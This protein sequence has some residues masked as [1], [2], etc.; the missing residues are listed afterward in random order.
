MKANVSKS[1]A[2]GIVGTIV[3]SLVILM[4]PYMGMP[5][6]SPPA[7]VAGMLGMP[8]IVGWIM[9][10]MI[11]IAYAFVYVYL[12]DPK[13]KIANTLLSGLLFGFLAFVFAKIM[14][15]IM[16]MAP[17]EGSMVMLLMATLIGHLVFGLGVAFTA[18]K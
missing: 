2:A 12:F 16:G 18:R 15:T 9:H 17:G 1:I 3:M 4:A 14:M 13:V 7:M 6:M 11:G 10:F 8:L 5:K